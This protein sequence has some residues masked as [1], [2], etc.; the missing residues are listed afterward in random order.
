MNYFDNKLVIF[1]ID[2]TL[3]DCAHRLH[4]VKNKPKNWP[5]FENK[6][7]FDQAIEPTKA[8]L[9]LIKNHTNAIILIVTARSIRM[10]E[11]TKTWLAD[12]NISYDKLYMR[13]INDYRGDHVVKEEIY[14]QILIDYNQKPV[15]VFDDRVKVNQ[16]W[17]E[18]G[19]WVF[20]CN[21]GEE[22]L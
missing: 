12:Q 11:L 9:Q 15:C 3:S 8:I 21:Q 16:M 20:D 14:N 4:L 1:D 10:E 18:Q 5:E 22:D 2:G 17:R 19:I 7:K 13:S 6:S